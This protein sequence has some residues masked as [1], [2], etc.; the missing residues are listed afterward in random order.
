MLGKPKAKT[1]LSKK[2]NPVQEQN[3]NVWGVIQNT[4]IYSKLHLHDMVPRLNHKFEIN[5]NEWYMNSRSNIQ[6]YKNL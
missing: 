1:T 5:A 2:P 3:W 6:I 4:D